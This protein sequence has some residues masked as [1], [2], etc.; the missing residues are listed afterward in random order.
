VT[1]INGTPVVPG[2]P[3]TIT[4][5][6]G[7]TVEI[8]EDGTYTY[9]PADG[10][11]GT[12]SIPYTIDDGMG[13]TDTATLYLSVFDLPPQ[14]EDDINTTTVDTPVTGDIMTNDSS[15]P[16]DTLTVG[17]GSGNPITG[18]LTLPTDQGGSIEISPDGTYE[19][20]PAPGFV[21]SDSVTLEVCDEAGNCVTEVLDVTV[22]E[23]AQNTPPIAENDNFETFS[24]PAAPATLSSDV[25]GNDGDPDADVIMVSEIDGQPVVP[26]TPITITT[27]NGGT[28]TINDD[29]TFDYTPAPGF[30][31]TDTFDYTIV[32]PSGESDTAT[33]SI[34]VQPDPDPA[35]NDDPDAND[36]G[37]ITPKNTPFNGNALDND[38]DPNGDALTVTE[39][40]GQPV[41]PGTPTTITL[42]SGSTVE[43]N[44]DGSY[45]YT[46]ANDFVGTESVVY[47][48]DDGMGGT[49]TA[50]I[51]LSTFD[52]PPEAEDD[53]ITTESGQP[54][55]GNLTVND[56]DPNGDDLTVASID[57]MPITGTAP[58]TIPVEDPNN[59]G[60]VVGDLTIDPVT[61]DYTFTPT[62]PDFSGDI[63]VPYEVADEGGST[64]P[65]VLTIYVV[66]TDPPE[67]PLDPSTFNNA[68]PIATDDE[69]SAQ[70]DTP[71]SSSVMSND[72]DP[73]GDVITIA[74][75]VTGDPATAPQTFPTTQG[76]TVTLNPDGTFTY[77][78]PAGYIGGDTFDYTIVDPSGATDTATVTLNVAPDPDPL[79]NDPPEAGDDLITSTVGEPA[80]GNMLDNDTDPNSDPL[81]ITVVDGQDPA[82]GPITL[83]DPVTGAIQ[84]VLDID[85]NTGEVTFTPEP[86][87]VG[88]VEVPYTIDDG[89]G[90]TD[91][92]TLTLTV[93]DEGPD[94]EDD[95]NATD[96]DTPVSGN[97][98]LNDTDSNPNDTLTVVDPATGDAATGPVTIPTTF[99]GTVTINPDGTY[100]YTPAPGFTG[101]DTFDYTV[102]DGFGKDDSATVSIE[103]RDTNAPADPLDPSTF[104][105]TPPI[106]TDDSFDVETNT[107]I[108]S[109]VMSNDG[110]PDGDPI[111]IA[112]P[113]TGDPATAPQTFPTA[114]GG[115]VTL[116]PDGTFDYTP[117]LDFIG[118]DTFDYTIVDPSGATDTATV[119]LE[120]SPPS[121]PSVNDPPSASDDLLVGTKN[122]P[123]TSNLLANDTDP[124]SDPLTVTEI[125]GTPID[126]VNPTTVTLPD[127]TLVYDPATGDATFTP[128]DDYT[129]SLQ[130]PYTITDPDGNTDTATITVTI[131][132]PPPEV[133]DD[134]NNTAIDT[135]VDGNILTN[136]TSD[137][138]D[139]LTVGDGSGNPLTG[140]A[141]FPTD[142]GGSVEINPDGSYTYTPAPGFTGEDTVTLEVCDEAGNCV[143]NVL[144]V[145][146]IDTTDPVNMDPLAENDEFETFSDPTAPA[147]VSS[148]LFGNDSDP[149]GDVIAVTDI[150]GTPVVPGTPTTVTTAN[151][152]TVTIN[153]D[154][155]F[156]YTPA[157]GFIGED[158]FDY[159]IVDPSGATDSATATF[160]VTPDPTPGVND[161][162]DANDD[163][164]L[165]QPETPASGNVLDNDT[166]PNGDPLTVTEIDGTPVVPGTPTT[167]TLP[168]GSTVEIADDGSYTYTPAPGVTGTE[169]VPYTIDDGNGG[170]DTATLI[171]AVVDAPPEAEDD[172]NLTTVD[173]PVDGNVLTNDVSDPGDVL[174]VGDGSGNPISGPTTMPTD[175]GGSIEIN[176]DGSYTYTPAPGFVGEDTVTIEIKDEGGNCVETELVVDVVDPDPTN[177]PPVAG[178]DFFEP[179]MDVPFTSSLGGNDG[180]PDGDV[181]APVDPVTGEAATAPITIP[182][183]AGGTVDINPDGTFT[184]TPPA[185]F[186]GEDSFDYSV[187]D[188]SGATDDA[189]VM[190]LVQA[191]PD[192]NVNDAPD[193]TDD[194][195]ITQ[196][197]VPATGDVLVNDTDPNGDPLTVTEIDGQ[198]VVPGTPTTVTLPS[199]S[200][201]EINDDGTYTYTPAPGFSGTEELPYTIDDGN[202]GTDTA[203]LHLTAFNLPPTAED[204]VIVTEPGL[205]VD[206]NLLTNDEDPNPGEDLDIGSINGTPITDPTTPV[207]VPVE[208]PNNPGTPVGTLTLDP[209]TG[210]YTFTPTDPDFT[211]TIEVPY[212]AVD[213]AGN[214][215]PATLTIE[216]V[217]TDPPVD[218]ADPSTFDNAPPIAT[219]DDF[220][221][222]ADTP[223]TSDVM[224]NDIDPNGDP[225]TIADPTGAPATTPI[226]IPTDQGG[227]VTLNPDGTFT[228]TPPAGF[229]G[230]DTFDYSIVDPS[231]ATDTATV[232]IDVE[233]D[234]DPLANDPPEAGEDVIAANPGEDATGNMLANDTDPNGD[235]LTI[236]DVNGQDPATGPITITDPVTGDPQ[237]VLTVDPNT[238][239]VVFTPEPDFVGT[240]EVPYTIDDGNGGTDDASLT[241][242]IFDE[243]PEATDDINATDLDTP[244]DGNVSFNDSDSNPNDTLTIVDPATGAPATGPVTVPTANGG[245]VVFQPDGSYTYTPAPGFVGEDTFPY[246]ISDS[247][248]KTDDAIVSI[249]V[250][251]TTAPDDPNDPTTINNA[252]PIA[253]DDAFDATTDQPLTSAVMSNDGDPDGD[254]ITIADPATGDPATGPQTITTDQGGT[255]TINPDGTFEYTPPA[256]FVGEDSFD[257]TIVD[258][259]GATDI[260]EVTLNVTPDDPTVNDP[261][262]AGDDLLVGT[263]NEP[264]TTNL[265]A[266]DS[267]PEADPLTVTDI[268]GTPIDPLVPTTVTLP[269]GTLEYDPFTGDVT[270]TPNDDFVGTVQVPYDVCD[271]SGNCDTATITAT[272]FDTDPEVLDDINNTPIDTPVEGNVLTNDNGG[273]PDDD[274]FV[275]DPSGNPIAP[276]TTFPTDNGGT[277][278]IDPDGSYVF[279]P[280]PGFTGEDTVTLT[281]CDEAGNCDDSVLSVDVV[282][283]VSDPNN[284]P[285]IAGDDNFEVFSDT[286]LNSSVMGNDGDPDGDPVTVVD[287]NTG[288]PATGPVTIPTD[289]GGSVTINPDGTFT[290]TPPAG[291]IGEDSFDYAIIDPNGATDTGSVT[292]NVE[293]DANPGEEDT[294]DAN[295]DAV[296]TP[297][298]VPVSSNALTN[299]TDPRAHDLILTE[300]DGVPVVPGT[301]TVVT[302]PSGGSLSID[303][304]GDF[305]YTPINDFVG[306]ESLPYSIEHDVISSL[307]ANG[308]GTAGTASA[309]IFLSTYG[310][311][312]VSGEKVPS[313]V[314]P[315]SS[316]VQGNFDVTYSFTLGNTGTT[317]LDNLMLTDDL[318]TSFGGA[319]IG[320]VSPPVITFSDATDDPG[321]NANFDGGLTDANI[322]DSSSSLLEELQQL[323]VQFTAE[324]DPDASTAVFDFVTG[325]GTGDLENQGEVTATDPLTGDPTM[326]MTDDPTDLTDDDGTRNDPSDDNGDP[327][328]VTGL[329]LPSMAVTKAQVGVALPT[330]FGTPGN[331]DLVYDFTIENTGNDRLTNLSL[332]ED[333]ATQFGGAFVQIFGSP[334]IQ[335]STATDDPEF[336]TAFDGGTTDA[337]LFDN[338]GINTNELAPGESVTVR[339]NVEVDPASPTANYV[340]G[341]LSNSATVNA[342]PIGAGGTLSASSDDPTIVDNEDDD[343]DNNPDDPTL[344]AL[345]SEISGNVFADVNN[346]GVF[347]PAENGILGVELILSGTD[348]G[349]N[350]VT[351]SVFADIDGAYTFEDVFPGDYTITQV[352]PS[353]FIDGS[354]A[355]GTLGGGVSN[356]QISVSIPPGADDAFEYNFGERGLRPEFISKAILL[357]STPDNYWA[358]LN[359]SGGGALG[360]WVPF[361]PE[362]GG[363]VNAVLIDAESIE[364]D[365]FDENMNL[366]NPAQSN[367][368]DATWIVHEG[369]R[370]FARLRGAD[371]N[372]DFSLAFGD[373]GLPVDLDVSENVVIAVGT[374]NDD[375]IELLL[376][377]QTHLLTIAGYTFM[378]DATIVDTF[379]IGAGGNNDYDSIRV[380]GTDLDDEASV[381]DT[382]GTFTSSHYSVTT[383]TFDSVTFEGGG[384]SDYT[385]IYG[386]TGDDTLQAIPQDTTLTTPSQVMQM[387]DFERVDSYGRGGDDY[388]SM[389][390]TQGDDEYYTFDTY[391]VLRSKSNSNAMTMRTIGWDRVD[392]FGR[393]GNDTA[394]LYD[395]AGDDHFY[396]FADYSVMKSDHLHAVVKGFEHVE[397]ESKNG[398]ND[399]AYF[400][401]V[402]SADHFFAAASIATLTAPSRSVWVGNFDELVLDTGDEEPSE[403][404]R[405]IDF[406]LVR[407]S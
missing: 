203:T 327:D 225:I 150:D 144:T 176:P 155:T 248:G 343:S 79:A 274:V 174:T 384:G 279:T 371:S 289:A 57:G 394:Y 280:P 356:D 341:F 257:Y 53:F 293:P 92:A 10:F 217:D 116:N 262:S 383:Y 115:T 17:D 349:G 167:I 172:I 161:D 221:S 55:D 163:A 393:G 101:E 8:N 370:Y 188:P 89:N 23:P 358:N 387:L 192:P 317:P 304:N 270:F 86:D 19:Y 241:I 169:T 4:L 25:F 127:G 373:E 126:P 247:F 120:V 152:G 124:E 362:V 364:V 321:I 335:S 117:P 332:T 36:D 350:P 43:I 309:T 375:E 136:D 103:V 378:F 111:T 145:D 102:V 271:P 377:A 395:T 63:E 168:S 131:F 295:D 72:S 81:T 211:G 231:G 170:T 141:T 60:T 297:E 299:D 6:S 234:P 77:T 45:T 369:Q 54:V 190:L 312:F 147:T 388:A 404:L 340:D 249:E 14:A 13:G 253:T 314:V 208:D 360:L 277:L 220:T 64:D 382:K 359:A 265:L 158:S 118:E 21:G 37:A 151:G 204:D 226:S 285:P 267:D 347:D 32:D 292:I 134:I 1:D 237:G 346:N 325:D 400:Q 282:D 34:D 357:A 76:G 182:T 399:R 91:T 22:V 65:A 133:E 214:T 245:T 130:V 380:V 334:T 307:S 42:P 236:T 113:A 219:D 396:A 128:N 316:G 191:D 98:L 88:A 177:T 135:P 243:G 114:Q 171:L 153:D 46:P 403:D 354:D 195:A 56:S 154:G 40:D 331:V 137:P 337:E 344:T 49:D 44:D 336:N 222:F 255:V 107:P 197:N 119:T 361:E 129:G 175:N 368:T 125:N 71:L 5:P 233:A 38:T 298:N 87:F 207:T 261:P 353:Q 339:I 109:D 74:D 216:V 59:P 259:S 239:D 33:V 345:T 112:D 372:F 104:N 200:T 78:P 108:S 323:T 254:A 3:T 12:E 47:T 367:D 405:E 110:D 121:D 218:P 15:E 264:T 96:I 82:A 148:T 238:G 139:D 278:S 52:N 26:G 324:I 223:L 61:G 184:Y 9:T 338:S 69:F 11:T 363:A 379:H 315:A 301:P 51:V 132:D 179:T 313:A 35:S 392:A 300:I 291:F 215:S 308:G 166:D 328:D 95:I 97:V 230:E 73:D 385:Q 18:P 251:D 173:T 209:E 185:G 275:S 142:N 178:D 333:L 386:S 366:L 276:G 256:G 164:V 48:V 27:A 186:T 58:V 302:T 99:G 143:E 187:I 258:P 68:P 140:P 288:A 90:G 213:E 319:F 100:E 105:N 365:I 235:P 252:P 286:P 202:G 199:G 189:T 123:T 250:R 122:E 318:V 397:A 85:P 305:T 329:F 227:S 62:D 352:H 283:T 157:P 311:P 31:G 287:P 391:E 66:D 242:T 351:M 80:S 355:A 198:P 381:L 181:I 16:N 212:E 330:A 156:D 201:V 263:K 30:I 50:T 159:T 246:T 67:N 406:S 146:V 296:I 180:D 106:A 376:G 374:A 348:I 284:T 244:V 342:S 266:N 160:N 322:F 268:N 206:G 75:P 303:S 407:I 228:Y 70:V 260:G 165:T 41:V 232:T 24:D 210:D 401:E 389:Y 229:T 196:M 310:H 281:V 7:S 194:T 224:S 39:I 20:T 162:P 84:G 306:T 193:A 183:A 240:V 269:E 320:I 138:D 273:D 93:F 326:D 83:T 149:D 205:P 402:V 272:V 94:A 28:V 29:G 390:G 2:T 294:P 398:G 290:Y